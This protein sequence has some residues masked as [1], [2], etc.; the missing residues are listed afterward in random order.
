MA[1]IYDK[2]PAGQCSV[3]KQVVVV[4]A[5]LGL[6]D[7][8]HPG[9]ASPGLFLLAGQSVMPA[10]KAVGPNAV[11]NA[12]AEHEVPRESFADLLGHGKDSATRKRE[13]TVTDSKHPAVINTAPQATGLIKPTKKCRR[14][15]HGGVLCSRFWPGRGNR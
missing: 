6:L 8:D 10:A 1:G 15:E 4:V 2:P 11:G 5:G 13:A 3:N 14:L 12:K 7:C 9:L